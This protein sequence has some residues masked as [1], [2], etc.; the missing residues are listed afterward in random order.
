MYYFTADP[1]FGHQNIISFANRPF[2]SVTE[3]NAVLIQNINDRCSRNDFL[4]MLGD[5]AFHM[6]KEQTEDILSSLIPKLVLIRGNHDREYDS[7]L[8]VEVKD[9]MELKVYHRKVVLCHYPFAEWNGMLRGAIHLHGHQHNQKDYNENMRE[10]GCL[11]YDVGIDANAFFPVS[12]R[13]IFDFF[14]LNTDNYQNSFKK[15]QKIQDA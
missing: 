8:F 6:P 4:F 14:N 9:Y 5:I 1:H 13:D 15:I 12:A 7:R 11:R 2:E 10:Q 3:M